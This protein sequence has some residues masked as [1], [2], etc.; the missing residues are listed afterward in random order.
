[1]APD[2]VWIMGIS[3][4]KIKELMKRPCVNKFAKAIQDR[5]LIRELE[6]SD[7]SIKTYLWEIDYFYRT[8]GIPL[9]EYPTKELCLNWRSAAVGKFAKKTAA[10]KIATLNLFLDI[11]CGYS[12]KVPQVKNI[13][14]ENTPAIITEKEVMDMVRFL[15]NKGMYTKAAMVY[16]AF[17]SAG[18]RTA[19][20]NLTLDCIKD[21]E[22]VFKHAKGD[23]QITVPMDKNDIDYIRGYI[24][25]HRTKPVEGHEKYLFISKRNGKLVST[26]FLHKALKYAATNCSIKVNVHPHTL[27]HSRV[28]DLRQ[29]GYSWEEIMEITGHEASSLTDY[30]QAEKKEIV[31]AKLNAKKQQESQRTTERSSKIEQQAP[32]DI[33]RLRLENENLRLQ[34]QLL[35]LKGEI[36]TTNLRGDTWDTNRG[37]Q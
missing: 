35:Q 21:D 22:I 1:M 11:V 32:S 13:T 34:L 24:E 17:K 3:E 36:R 5:I 12:W 15:E 29:K 37:Y 2:G 6:L 16:I 14:R 20:Q 8:N 33:E 4:R 28:K 10:R 30:I 7:G 18:R 27:R 23:K 19:V 25:Y 31:K 26:E 9:D